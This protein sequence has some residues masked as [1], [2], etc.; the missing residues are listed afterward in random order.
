M[1]VKRG[2]I[3]T[4]S[5]GTDY[6]S[7]PRPIVIVQDDRFDA[8]DS[9]TVCPFTSDPAT[10]PIF[11]LPIMPSDINGLRKPSRLMVDKITTIPKAKLGVR[12]GKLDSEDMVWLNRSIIVFL[13]MADSSVSTVDGD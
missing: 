8:T 13:G 2:D 7:K 5:G 12:I 6:A 10:S 4:A 9:I 1:I 3:W 11:R